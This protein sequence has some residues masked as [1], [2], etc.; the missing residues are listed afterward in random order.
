MGGLS[1]TPVTAVDRKD[2]LN[3]ALDAQPARSSG[4]RHDRCY[5]F[6]CP[7]SRG[8]ATARWG[9]GPRRDRKAGG[10]T[11]GE[12]DAVRVDTGGAATGDH[13]AKRRGRAG[14]RL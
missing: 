1:T 14:L 10:Q 6:G 8:G 9:R 3:K 13:R 4:G 2:E 7:G 11:A 12:Q 5:L